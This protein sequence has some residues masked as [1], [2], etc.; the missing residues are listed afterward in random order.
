MMAREES[1]LVVE[2]L[3]L[4]DSSCFS[5]WPAASNAHNF[6]EA[7]KAAERIASQLTAPI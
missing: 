6:G 1:C 3:Q 2:N 4:L 7:I 5:E